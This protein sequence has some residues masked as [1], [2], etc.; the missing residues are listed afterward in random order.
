MLSNLLSNL[1]NIVSFLDMFLLYSSITCFCLLTRLFCQFSNPLDN[2][3]YLEGSFLII[4]CILFASLVTNCSNSSWLSIC[5]F[6]FS[7]GFS[8]LVSLASVS[9]LYNAACSWIDLNSIVSLAY[10]VIKLLFFVSKGLTSF[11]LFFITLL[12]CLSLW[13]LTAWPVFFWYCETSLLFLKSPW[14]FSIKLIR[15]TISSLSVFIK[16]LPVSNVVAI[17]LS[18]KYC[19]KSSC[20]TIVS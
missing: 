8:T 11:M 6:S 14:F 13:F 18:I 10:L 5:S 16:E 12:Y 2:S 7:L 19:C 15:F 1:F 9:F 4:S 17:P 20:A 3:S